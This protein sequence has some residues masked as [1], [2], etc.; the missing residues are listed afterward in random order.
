[1]NE[2]RVK[3][4]VCLS[5]YLDL[6]TAVVCVLVD[7]LYLGYAHVHKVRGGAVDRRGEQNT[8]FGTLVGLTR[9]FEAQWSGFFD[10][11]D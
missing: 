7:D 2:P 1:M 11:F 8:I 5:L 9:P 4:L 10:D 3:I 6:E